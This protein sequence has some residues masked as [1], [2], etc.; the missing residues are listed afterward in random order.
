MHESFHARI[1]RKSKNVHRFHYKKNYLANIN[2]A[3]LLSYDNYLFIHNFYSNS[4]QTV[5]IETNFSHLAFL[6]RETIS[7][8]SLHV[9]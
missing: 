7:C 5:S 9:V 1:K 4:Q 3:S 8:N 2:S 6:R